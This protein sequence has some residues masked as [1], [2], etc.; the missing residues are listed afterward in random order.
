MELLDVE[1]PLNSETVINGEPRDGIG[2]GMSNEKFMKFKVGKMDIV[3]ILC[4]G[5][6]EHGFRKSTALNLKCSDILRGN[7]DL[8]RPLMTNHVV[9]CPPGCQDKIQFPVYGNVMFHEK[10]S[11]C[12]AALFAGYYKDELGGEFIAQL[13]PSPK[14]YADGNNN[15]IKSEAIPF[16]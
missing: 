12:R 2:L 1:N 15:N 14:K 9:Y 4:S 10:S 8:D 7:K 11:I 6:S 5:N 16:P 13:V 3:G